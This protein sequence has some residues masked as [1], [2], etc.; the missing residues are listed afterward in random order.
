V[1]NTKE[2]ICMTLALTWVTWKQWN[3]FLFYWTHKK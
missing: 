3:V 1:N 2:Q